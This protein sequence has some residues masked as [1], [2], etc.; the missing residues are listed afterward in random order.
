MLRC[1]DAFL[2]AQPRVPTR[3]LWIVLT[4]PSSD[5]DQMVIVNVT[6]LRKGADTTVVLQPGDHPFIVKPSVIYY[7]G[8]RVVHVKNV[9]KGFAAG[10]CVPD[11]SCSPDLMA[12]IQEGLLRSRF[13]PGAV[14]AFYRKRAA[15]TASGETI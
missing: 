7:A 10:I 8:A 12:R 1:G 2:M 3:H 13:T 4:E 5:A 6:S 15:S 9:E 11:D 14:A